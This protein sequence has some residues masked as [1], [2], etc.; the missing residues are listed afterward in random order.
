MVLGGQAQSVR[1]ILFTGVLLM[2]RLTIGITLLTLAVTVAGCAKHNGAAK[3]PTAEGKSAA[4]STTEHLT[5][6]PIEHKAMKP[7]VAPAEHM[8]TTPETQSSETKKPAAAAPEPKPE[9]KAG[10]TAKPEAKP[11]TKLP[12]VK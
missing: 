10:E 4:S 9:G 8:G 6:T 5:T 7:V 2:K 11:E 3:K 12:D 1:I